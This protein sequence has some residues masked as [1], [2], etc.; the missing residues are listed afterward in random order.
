LDSITKAEDGCLVKER[1][2]LKIDDD[3]DGGGGVVLKYCWQLLLPRTMIGDI[4]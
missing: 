4:R 2:L 1:V 3:D